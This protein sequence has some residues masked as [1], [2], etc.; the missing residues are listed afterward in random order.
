MGSGGTIDIIPSLIAVPGTRGLLVRFDL[1]NSWRGT[2]YAWELYRYDQPWEDT[3]VFADDHDLPWARDLKRRLE[4]WV[5]CNP[6]RCRA[7]VR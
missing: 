1:D 4:R 5:D 3:N 2:D 6:A 7:A